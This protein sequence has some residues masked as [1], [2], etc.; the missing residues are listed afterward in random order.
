MARRIDREVKVLKCSAITL[1]PALGDKEMGNCICREI[2]GRDIK[3]SLEEV[4]NAC[5]AT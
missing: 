5:Y 1:Q 4:Q 2:V 3:L